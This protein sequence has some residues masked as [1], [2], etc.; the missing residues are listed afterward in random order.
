MMQSKGFRVT[1]VVYTRLCNDVAGLDRGL[2]DHGGGLGGL[3]LALL[4]RI[5]RSSDVTEIN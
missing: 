5:C 3:S 2:E 4:R 1:L